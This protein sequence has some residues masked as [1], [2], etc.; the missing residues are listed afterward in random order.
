MQKLEEVIVA[1]GEQEEYHD[2]REGDHNGR[3]QHK[4]RQNDRDHLVKFQPR[5]Q[6]ILDNKKGRKADDY[7]QAE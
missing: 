1:A 2:G 7:H 3:G 5:S 4:A 6:N